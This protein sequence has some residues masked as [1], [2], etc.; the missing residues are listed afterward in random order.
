ML[1]LKVIFLL[2][3]LVHSADL[4]LGLKREPVGAA[5]GSS[6]EA[7]L[8]GESV[9]RRSGAPDPRGPEED[10]ATVEPPATSTVTHTSSGRIRKVRLKTKTINLVFSGRSQTSQMMHSQFVSKILNPIKMQHQSTDFFFTSLSWTL[11]RPNVF[12]ISSL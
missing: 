12:S 8:K 1:F 4:D 3:G 10:P 11:F 6:L 5:D 7:L 2:I 9:E